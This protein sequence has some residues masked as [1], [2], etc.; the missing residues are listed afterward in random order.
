MKVMVVGA[1]KMGKRLAT[2]LAEEGMDVTV[3]D[4]NP[5]VI[6]RVNNDLDV[7]TVTGN[8]LDF[9]LL[10]ELEI[11]TYDL[12]IATISSDESNV[13]LSSIAKRLGC[14]M[15]VAR[16]RDPQYHKQINFIL[17]ELDIDY[18]INPDSATAVAIE[19]YLLKK[20]SLMSDEFADGKVKLVEFNISQK[21]SFVGK[22][23]QDLQ[24]F[25][26]LLISAISRKGRTIIPNG[27]TVLQENDAILVI[28]ASADI[29]E[30]DRQHSNLSASKPVKRVLVLGGGKLGQYLTERLIEDHIE[31]TVI[32]RDL[33]R[34]QDLKEKVPH[35][36]VIH[37][38]GTNF[39]LIQEEMLDDIDAFVAATGID[40]T[41]ILMALAMK[42]EG[43]AKSVAK[44]SRPNFISILDRLH[45][46]A[47]FNPSFITA[48]VI[49]KMV[50]GKDALAIN[51]MI[52]GD[53]EITEIRLDKNLKIFDTPLKDL[54]LPKGMLISAIVRNGQVVIPNGKEKLQQGDRIIVFCLHKNIKKMKEYFHARKGGVLSELWSRI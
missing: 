13:L 47:S 18:I 38:D 39:D 28:G 37:G 33:E 2:S 36:M 3:L 44:I 27:Q 43:V 10:K 23:L 24:G 6:Q 42:E 40:E 16:V 20:Y 54:N 14:K 41:N 5:D 32:E 1:G 9:S 17:K 35:A 46:D 11:E 31:V 49:L 29:D 22:K 4:Q 25:D 21:S 53:A 50:R 48:S 12:L 30:F 52:D 26:R 7:L 19:K 45:L 15:A 8:A 34:A 51:L